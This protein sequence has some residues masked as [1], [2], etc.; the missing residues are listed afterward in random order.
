VLGDVR[1]ALAAV[2]EQTAPLAGALQPLR[3][4]ATESAEDL[5]RARA[6]SEGAAEHLEALG[7]QR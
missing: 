4:E 3:D 5:A 2:A 7:Q 6:G 1:S